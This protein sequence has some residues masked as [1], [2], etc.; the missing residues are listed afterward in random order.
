MF[1]ETK[2]DKDKALPTDVIGEFKKSILEAAKK[3][4]N[5]LFFICAKPPTELLELVEQHRDEVSPALKKSRLLLYA[6]YNLRT[7]YE[8]AKETNTTEKFTQKIK[9]LFACFKRVDIVGK[10]AQVLGTNDA[11][12]NKK[13][14]KVFEHLM[15]A[16]TQEDGLLGPLTKLI[17]RW[18][19]LIL[20]KAKN[21]IEKLLSAAEK[22][23]KENKVVD[24]LL[25]DLDIQKI[26]KHIQDGDRF[27]DSAKLDEETRK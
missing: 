16:Q 24:S 17:S 2:E 3:E 14:P 1:P 15:K 10:T 25:D 7:L 20:S 19:K 22:A 8:Q 18:N 11:T 6:S 5:E 12:D 26:M 13:D 27:G 4:N 23:K 21:K 9:N